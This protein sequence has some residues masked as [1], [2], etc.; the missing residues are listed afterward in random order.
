LEVEGWLTEG[1]QTGQLLREKDWSRTILGPPDKWPEALR[2]LVSVILSSSQPMFLAWGPERRMIYNDGYAEIMQDR[3]PAAM[4]ES[5]DVVWAD[6]LPVVG[7]IMD[8]GYAGE[9]SFSDD[10]ELSIL[11]NG[12]PTETHFA[13]SYSPIRA[14]IG[15]VAGVFC[16]CIE[17]TQQVMAERNRAAMEREYRAAAELVSLSLDS[18][19]VIGTWVWDIDSDTL[20]GDARLADL[21]DADIAETASGLP[22]S[23]FVDAIHP[24][25]Q[26]RVMSAIAHAA[27]NPGPFHSEYR[28]RGRSGEYR[29]VS[30]TG[31][32]TADQAGRAKR[33]PGVLVDIELQR[34]TEQELRDTIDQRTLLAHE[35]DH[36]VK[37]ILAMVN[38]I[39]HQT[40]RPPATLAGA[41][42]Q[43]SQRIRAL[44]RAQDILTRTSWTAADILDV[45]RSAIP[46]ALV[47]RVELVGLPIRLPAKTALGLAL[48]VHELG[49]NAVKYGALSN[50]TGRVSVRWSLDGVESK[51]GFTLRWVESGGPPVNPPNRKG[52][53]T[54]LITSALEAEFRG[55]ARI[56]YL[57]QG[58]RFTLT[59]P[60][61]FREST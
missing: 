37:N 45:V 38:A 33:F 30:A 55:E 16:S 1:G 36:R 57:P 6:I 47:H 27:E 49:T 56:D 39:A 51:N 58:V 17:T 7:P 41:A 13:F 5:F 54:R 19:A 11:R 43:F 52:F 26:P 12:T 14:R 2:A 24:D 29:W 4:G 59:S 53:G 31:V 20:R 60:Y 23:T 21:F 8:R 9:P 18:G 46:T 61:P 34:R 25:D 42:E 32:V 3:H 44:A 40:F 28:V 50:D 48:A 15:E 35:L 22:L 10:L